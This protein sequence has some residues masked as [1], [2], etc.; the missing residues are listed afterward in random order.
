[1]FLLVSSEIWSDKLKLLYYKA[2]GGTEERS[3]KLYIEVPMAQRAT[4]I[5]RTES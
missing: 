3:F 2:H 5:L 1:M 4:E